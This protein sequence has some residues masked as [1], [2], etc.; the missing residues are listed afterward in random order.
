MTKLGSLFDGS[1]GFPLAG[2]M[3][4]I[5]PAWA[6]EIEPYPIR[7][8]TARFPAMKHLGDITKINGAEIEPVDIITFGSPCQDLSVAGK[9]AG[10]HK[11]ERSSLFFEAIRIIKEMREAS[12]GEFPRVIVWENVPGAFSSNGGAD[13]T[14][15]LDSI[16]ELGYVID[17][18]VLDAQHMGV[19]QRRRRIY[20][21]GCSANY[22]A[23]M[24]TF[25]SWNI[26]TQMLIEILL[27]ILNAQLNLSEA[28]RKNSV[29]NS[30]S[31]SEDGLRRK[32]KLFAI[33]EI[34]A[35]NR[36]LKDWAETSLTYLKEPSCLE[37]SSKEL[38]ATTKT[39]TQPGESH[40]MTEAERLIGSISRSW[41][42]ILGENLSITN[43]YTILIATSETTESTI[44][45]CAI[46]LEDIRRLIGLFKNCYQVSYETELYLSTGRKASINYARARQTSRTMFD[47][48]E[49]VQRWDDYLRLDTETEQHLIANTGAKRGSEVLPLKEGL[50]G[51]SAESGK[52][53]EGAAGDA[54]GSVDGSVGIGINGEIAGTL[55]A[56]YYKGCG[57]RQGVERE[58]VVYSFD[59]LSSFN[60]GINTEGS[61]GG[62][63]LFEPM[64]ALEENWAESTVKNALRA[65]ASKSSH[66]VCYPIDLIRESR[67]A[68]ETYDEDA[69]IG[70]SLKQSDNKGSQVVCYPINTMVCNRHMA[71]DGRTCIGYG[72]PN[73]PQFTL[74]AN[75]SHAVCYALQGD[76]IDRADTAG[77]NGGGWRK[78]V[79]YTP[80]TIDRPAVCFEQ[81]IVFK[82]RAG[83][84]GGGKGILCGD[85]PFTLSTLQD[86]AVCY[87]DKVG[88]LC[89]TD[90]KWVQ[91]QQVDQDK[92][93]VYSAGNGQVDNPYLSPDVAQTLNCMHDQQ[94][95]LHMASGQAN[96]EIGVNVACTLTNDKDRMPVCYSMQRSDMYEQSDVSCTEAARQYKS[97][98]DLVVI[99]PLRKY[100][101]RRLTP[102]ECCRLQGFPNLWE[103]GLEIKHPTEEQLDF[104]VWV[105]NTFRRVTGQKGKPWKRKQA[106]AWIR[107]QGTDSARYKMWGNGIALPCAAFVLGRVADVIGR[108]S[109]VGSEG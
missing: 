48:V 65:E 108:R 71:D 10:L 15:V 21:L 47:S 28:E 107:N 24:K 68:F 27:T 74:Q 54:T 5:E 2:A 104:W 89:A 59:S 45:G 11:G 92:I 105:L 83:C 81:P 19:P 56:N 51:D 97:A 7:V 58:V 78:D 88:A 3:H 94:I 36:L 20:L 18:N 85:K 50:R 62:G 60:Q 14:A 32:M 17:M 13:I 102:L 100:I 31:L 25:I 35:F 4:G 33:E 8:T 84:P 26:I 39:D 9:Q 1:G 34:V 75:H 103:S 77:C 106:S 57:L 70:G 23:K 76:G 67:V 30:K 12:D 41:R 55:D 42:I 61:A 44:Y 109:G 46:L 79:C 49:W 53:G 98:T 72:Q 66:A 95:V 43:L 63:V 90:Y 16:Q 6:S 22:I 99:K 40:S 37:S 52:A 86:Q 91:Q 87:Q 80:D 69:K 93:I 82:E 38:E 29:W 101:I 73:D 96:A 64:S